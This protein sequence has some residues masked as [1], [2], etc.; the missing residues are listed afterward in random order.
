VRQIVDGKVYDTEKAELVAH[1][2]YWDGHNWD[3]RGRNTYLYKT[4]K[5]LYRT[6]RQRRSKVLV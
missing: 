1:D 4:K 2:R 6:C 3:R 5:E